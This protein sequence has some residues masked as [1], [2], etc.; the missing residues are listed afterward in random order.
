M[1]LFHR[2]DQ[3]GVTFEL[4][5]LLRHNG[6]KEY[7]LFLEAG[8]LLPLRIHLFCHLVDAVRLSFPVCVAEQRL[9]HAPLATGTQG[10]L[11]RLKVPLLGLLELRLE[12]LDG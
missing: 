5:I 8:Q 11:N 4:F 12:R 2:E 7:D 1:L 9:F 10:F 6:L 3:I